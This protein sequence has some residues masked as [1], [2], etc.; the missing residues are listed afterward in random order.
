MLPRGFNPSSS[1]YG[2]DQN[3]SGVRLPNE[4]SSSGNILA[5]PSYGNRRDF[6]LYAYDRMQTHL[7]TQYNRLGL[8]NTRIINATE[9]YYNKYK[10]YQKAEREGVNSLDNSTAVCDK[11]LELLESV[12]QPLIPGESVGGN[13]NDTETI[14]EQ[15]QDLY[16]VLNQ[17]GTGSLL[18]IEEISKQISDMSP[19][20]QPSNNI[21]AEQSTDQE[22]SKLPRSSQLYNA[23]NEAFEFD[24]GYST[25]GAPFTNMF[26]TGIR[27]RDGDMFLAESI[28]RCYKVGKPLIMA[29]EDPYNQLRTKV[30]LSSEDWLRIQSMFLQNNF[31]SEVDLQWLLEL[32]FATPMI[33]GVI[34][35]LK[36]SEASWRGAVPVMT[37]M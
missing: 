25:G 33:S 37:M 3:W 17:S 13:T 5:M 7:Y 16:R 30:E 11:S 22:M 21:E 15:S 36:P 35:R 9:V 31:V 32:H 8:R 6:E 10:K 29:S 4:P 28:F 18:Q 19:E 2:L 1:H 26:I 34:A 20:N 27:H 23:R 14:S 24:L 12:S